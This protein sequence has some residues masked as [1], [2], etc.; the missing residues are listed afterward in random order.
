[1]GLIDRSKEKK[2]KQLSNDEKNQMAADAI[3]QILA[4]SAQMQRRMITNIKK[5]IK[6]APGSKATILGLLG[7]EEAEATSMINKLKDFANAH[8]GTNDQ[9]LTV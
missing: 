3:Q 8:K 7:D 1:M 4:R 6:R 9:D 5:I 2:Q